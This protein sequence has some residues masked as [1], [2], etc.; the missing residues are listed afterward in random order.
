MRRLRGFL[1]RLLPAW[2]FR[3]KIAGFERRWDLESEGFTKQGFFR[4]FRKQFRLDEKAGSLIELAVG[5]GLVGSLGLWLETEIP[6]WKVRAWEHREE[7]C[8][9][10]RRHR[11][12][13]EIHPGRITNWG[14]GGQDMAPDA[15][16]T[17]GMREASGVCRAIRSGILRPSWLGI[18]NPRR[19]AVWYR[20][21]QPEGY[22]LELV[23]Q[24]IEF[25]GDGR[26]KTGDR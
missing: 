6:A 9:Q 7:V 12:K 8:R 3:K 22:R 15:I 10:F 26:R 14:R 13:T 25:Y 20:R 19:R 11:P 2:G 4:I 21:L 18:W 1:Y 17:R 5:D 23:W 24:N 16:T